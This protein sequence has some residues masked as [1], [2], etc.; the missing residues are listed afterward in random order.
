[1]AEPPP[2]ASNPAFDAFVARVAAVAK[3][4][5]T[6]IQETAAAASGQPQQDA[7]PAPGGGPQAP[8]PAASQPQ[9]AAPETSAGHGQGTPQPHGPEA[10]PASG[11]QSPPHDHGGTP[12]GGHDEAAAVL[13]N[14]SNLVPDT[15]KPADPATVR[16]LED[17]LKENL[18][19][20][21][22]K[23][24]GELNRSFS[25]Y[26]TVTK[27][28]QDEYTKQI[29][30]EKKNGENSSL[31]LQV[32][33][34]LA[35]FLAG[36]I[37][38]A[39]TIAAAGTLISKV[40]ASAAREMTEALKQAVETKGGE[41]VLKAARDKLNEY[42]SK[43]L[44]E[45]GTKSEKL[46]EYLGEVY[47]ALPQVQDTLWDAVDKAKSIGELAVV[48]KAVTE[49]TRDAFQHRME[50]HLKSMERDLAGD[51]GTMYR[52]TIQQPNPSLPGVVGQG[53]IRNVVASVEVGRR[54]YVAQVRMTTYPPD[55]GQGAPRQERHV[56]IFGDWLDSKKESNVEIELTMQVGNRPLGPQEIQV[57]SNKRV[58]D[59]RSALASGS[60]HEGAG[61]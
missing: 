14:G 3:A 47:K 8:Q 22:N 45:P 33:L 35:F 55:E 20:L 21:Q 10:P 54:R 44:M 32:G 57:P 27:S 37:A 43:A 5:G 23:V 46:H 52:G 12:H 61:H 6:R 7:E 50:E 4:A 48:Y 51:A 59:L 42:V 53:S 29:E 28:L 38:V 17:F 40:N 13:G 41:D 11:Q 2:P 31:V 26:Q 34:T 58:P 15:S 24:Q 56:Y 30:L 19:V 9:T 60:P 1:M 25:G 49:L 39:A 18:S 16:K 36:E